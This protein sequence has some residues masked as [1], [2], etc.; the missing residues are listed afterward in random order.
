VPSPSHADRTPAERRRV[1]RELECI[2][3]DVAHL[4]ERLYRTITTT[5]RNERE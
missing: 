2:A 5:D 4:H 3:L 1:A